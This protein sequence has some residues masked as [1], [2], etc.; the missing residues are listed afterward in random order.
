VTD[1][2]VDEIRDWLERNRAELEQ[3]Q[4]GHLVITWGDHN[5]EYDLHRIERVKRRAVRRLAG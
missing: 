5:V 1:S 4:I 2:H 3:M